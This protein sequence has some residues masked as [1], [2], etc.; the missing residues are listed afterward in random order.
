A[1]GRELLHL[2]RLVE[3]VG[4]VPVLATVFS[5]LTIAVKLSNDAHRAHLVADPEA[6][7]EGLETIADVTCAFARAAIERGCAGIFFAVQEA[8]HA[9][10]AEDQYREF[11]EPYDLRV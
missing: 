7:R 4:E 5:P 8:S 11:G 3:Q 9:V 10:L 2:E 6:V 1:F